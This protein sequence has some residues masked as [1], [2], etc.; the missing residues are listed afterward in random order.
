MIFNYRR[1]FCQ[2]SIAFVAIFFLTSC[3][4]KRD[5][6]SSNPPLEIKPVYNALVPELQEARPD[7]TVAAHLFF[8]PAPFGHPDDRS[9]NVVIVTAARSKHLYQLDTRSGGL[10]RKQ[11]QCEH[12]DI[13]GKFS[14]TLAEPPFS[15]A[16]VPRM[17]DVLGEPQLTFNFGDPK[18]LSSR[19]DDPKAYRM[20]VVGGVIRQVCRQYPCINRERWLSNMQLIT[21][22][23]LD[24]KFANVHDLE[25]L[26]S[27]VD[28]ELAVAWMQNGFGV[29]TSGTK[30]EPVYRVTGEVD[31]TRVLG[32][33]LKKNR[34][35]EFEEQKTMVSA[36]HALYESLWQTALKA[37]HSNEKRRQFL[38]NSKNITKEV[39]EGYSDLER[40][41]LTKEQ[42]QVDLMAKRLE[43]KKRDQEGDFGR[44][45]S[46]FHNKYNRNYKTC[47]RFVRAASIV[48]DAQ[49]FWFFAHIDL[50]MWLEELGWSYRCSN[51]AWLENPVRGDGK[52][53][54][55]KGLENNC[56]T[57]EL[58]NAFSMAVT[59]MNGE[60]KAK[61]PHVRFISYDSGAGGSHHKIYGWVHEDGKELVCK[62][63]KE[64]KLL[65]REVVN[66]FP[67][68]INWQ[69]FQLD[70]GR[71]RYDIIQ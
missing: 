36:C 30:P 66:I 8:D 7:G 32:F 5:A 55:E 51:K 29:T 25:Q 20:R 16:V 39:L 43:L 70:I 41:N 49:R 19:F 10:F 22:N 21:V 46:E 54:F 64:K 45:F 17:L 44:A 28:W 18:Y 40:L 3:A 31:A 59:V 38:S 58:D 24:P 42:S 52:R 9:V 4:G 67:V 69:P 53:V 14:D 61:R 57:Q 12:N 23:P 15:I 26:K 13:W 1:S 71:S 35:L 48:K 60:R 47:M 50:F 62:D 68:D 34:R 27:K 6:A 37:R 11:Y 56:T 63:E 2:I 65:E 33:F